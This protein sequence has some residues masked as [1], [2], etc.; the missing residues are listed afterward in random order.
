VR[1]NIVLRMRWLSR[2]L[3]ALLIASAAQAQPAPTPQP[4]PAPA[5]TPA[6]DAEAKRTELEAQVIEVTGKVEYAQLDAKPL[7]KSAWKK[8]ESDMRLPADTQIRTSLRSRCVLMF[9]E[10]PD[11]TVISVRR[12]S[13]A[14]ISDYY[15]TQNEQRIRLGLGYGAIRGGSSEGELRSDVVIESTVATLA[16]RGTEGFEMEVEP[17]SGYYRI[18]LAESGLVEALAAGARRGRLVRPGEYVTSATL[19]RLWIQQARFDRNV[20]FVATEAATY[21]DL[22]FLTRR[23]TGLANVGPFGPEVTVP[24][25][26]RVDPRVL[27]NVRTLA[28]RRQAHTI[29]LEHFGQYRPEGNFGLGR[30]FRVLMPK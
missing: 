9:G 8:V 14:S 6:P 27:D 21:R 29:L 18:A 17:V 5:A 11:Q 19:A 4:T 25:R 12:A 15:R 3:T 2:G 16:K 20:R 22:E 1:Y 28:D 7:D 26:R 24:V 10:A 30:T 23:T 13:L